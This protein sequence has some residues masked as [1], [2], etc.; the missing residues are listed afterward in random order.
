MI[1]KHFG[2]NNEF[3]WIVIDASK[4]QANQNIMEKYNLDNELMSYALD[5]NERA[6]LEY[7]SVH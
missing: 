3:Q 1:E 7:D 6:H 5:K 2:S 4:E